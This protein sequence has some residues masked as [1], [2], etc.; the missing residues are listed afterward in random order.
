MGPALALGGMFLA[1]CVGPGPEADAALHNWL[2]DVS[3]HSV[4]YAY[5]MLSRSATLRTQYDPF[6][7]GV[8]SSRAT[9]RVVSLK[10][11]SADDVVAT[12]RVSNPGSQ[13][14]LVKVQ[15]VEEGNGGDWLVGAPFSTEGA[16]AIR[17]F[18]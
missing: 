6:F 10:V 8:N 9:F 7:N 2:A 5:T 12:V 17:E 11:V 1:G 16:R 15:V 14:H 3:A 13:P 4:A 18:Q